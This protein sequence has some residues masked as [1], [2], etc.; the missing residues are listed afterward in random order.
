MNVSP[1]TLGCFS[2]PKTRVN[3][4]K[5]ACFVSISTR[6]GLRQIFNPSRSSVACADIRAET[7]GEVAR[8]SRERGS[9]RRY[10]ASSFKCLRHV[11]A[12]EVFY[13]PQHFT[14]TFFSHIFIYQSASGTTYPTQQHICLLVRQLKRQVCKHLDI[15]SQ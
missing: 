9:V 11:R 4:E 13:S 1:V 3:N 15:L 6:G 12:G 14:H 8:Q 2:R 10:S 7:S 5:A